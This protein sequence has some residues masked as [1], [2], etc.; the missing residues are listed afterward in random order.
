MIYLQHSTNFQQ[1]TLPVT[2][3]IPLAGIGQ[4][5]FLLYSSVNRKTSVE[6]ELSQGDFNTDYNADFAIV[7][8]PLFSESGRFYK[9]T[10]GFDSL[11]AVGEY[12]YALAST[13]KV[14]ARGLAIVGDYH[15]AATTYNDKIEYKQYE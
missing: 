8:E 15:R 12:E 1:I 2:E 3:S 14:L 6:Y 5:K 7:A 10:I 11:P 13:T 4:V 9:F